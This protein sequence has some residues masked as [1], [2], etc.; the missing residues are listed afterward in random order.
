MPPQRL[1]FELLSDATFGRGAGTVGEVDVEVEHDISG[2]PFV[3]GKLLHGL[4][5]DAWL[6]MAAPFPELADAGR[7]LLGIA[8][9]PG[10]AA[11]LRLG[12][13]LLP[14]DVRAWVRHAVEREHHPLRPDQVLRTLTDIRRQAAQSRRSGAP[15][16][17]TLRSARV[18]L[19]GLIFEAPLTWLREPS[20]A[21]LQV[22]AL[23]VLGVRHGGLGRNRGRG[24]LRLA[25]DGD[26][27]ATRQLAGLPPGSGPSARKTS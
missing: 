8:A 4:V 25:L 23:S 11:L 16:E 9:D 10:D 14:G 26:P 27:A 21:H 18:V 12:D 20:A 22:L 15:E 7:E 17:T 1:T 24:H 5:R 3:S 19:R 6:S 13:A 2:L